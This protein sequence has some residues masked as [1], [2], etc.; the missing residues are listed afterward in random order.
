MVAA[1]AF[2]KVSYS[3]LNKIIL[4]HRCGKLEVS[5]KHLIILQA[6]VV[7]YNSF[8]HCTN[9]QKPH[10]VQNSISDYSKIQE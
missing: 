4:A 2:I 8:I 6:T 7:P 10:I 9:P 3:N 5:Q 1:Q